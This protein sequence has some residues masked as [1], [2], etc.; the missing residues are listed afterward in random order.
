MTGLLEHSDIKCTNNLTKERSHGRVVD[1]SSN[2]ADLFQSYF[3][4]YLYTSTDIWDNNN[5]SSYNKPY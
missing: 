4:S 2:W 5:T 1:S 3:M